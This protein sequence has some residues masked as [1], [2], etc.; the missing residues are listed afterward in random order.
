QWKP[1]VMNLFT[2]ERLRYGPDIMTPNMDLSI[3][4]KKTMEAYEKGEINEE[5]LN[6]EVSKLKL[7]KEAV[8]KLNLSDNQF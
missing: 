7:I 4:A 3:I 1:A 6:N 2:R 5:E 8:R